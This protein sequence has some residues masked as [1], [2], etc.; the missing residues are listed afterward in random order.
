MKYLYTLLLFFVTF[1]I[2]A[3]NETPTEAING[4]YHLLEAERG[5]SGP[6]KIKFIE[7]G[8]NN[9]TK[10]LAVAA[11][12]KCMPAIYT[13]KEEDSK[14][15]GV[16]VFFNSSGLY[17]FGYDKD[18]FVIVLVTSM[19]GDKPWESFAF[20]NLYTKNAVTAK[21]IGKDKIEAYAKAL[22]KK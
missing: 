18:S 10:L 11:C 20:S 16:P 5:V 21:M 7:F 9:G 17:V 12:E 8:E 19:L 3:Q 22:S 2:S 14:R 1:L 13:Y 15:L 4:K 6:T